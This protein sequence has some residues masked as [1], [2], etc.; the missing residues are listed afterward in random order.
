[1]G[2][3]G[4]PLAPVQTL[5]PFVAGNP[6]FTLRLSG[7]APGAA[8]W[9]GISLAADASGGGP[10][11][12]DT[13]P[14]QLIWPAPSAGQFT[15]DAGGQAVLFAAL[16]AGGGVSGAAFHTQWLVQDAQGAFAFLGGTYTLSE[17]RTLILF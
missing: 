9:L 7:A 5:S 11:W 3:S 16:P 6:A 4:S 15:T 1:M 12:L 2:S 14:G 17:A 13:S 10:I 8:C